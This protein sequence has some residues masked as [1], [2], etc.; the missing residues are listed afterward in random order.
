MS[1]VEGLA[2]EETVPDFRL[3]S[4]S[5]PH[6]PLKHTVD[7]SLGSQARRV[8]I[9]RCR[10]EE[11]RPPQN[12]LANPCNPDAAL[13][14]LSGK[15]PTP[16]D[17]LTKKLWSTSANT[18]SRSQDKRQHPPDENYCGIRRKKVVSMFRY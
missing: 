14:A 2:R 7:F 12:P 4:P 6:E 11:S 17:Q 8:L 18:N 5:V 13:A 3:R 10:P 1:I 15:R 9:A 16:P